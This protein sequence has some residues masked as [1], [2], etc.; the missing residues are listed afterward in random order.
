M[1]SHKRDPPRPSDTMSKSLHVGDLVYL[2]GDGNKNRGR[3]RYII[4]SIEGEWCNIRKLT[5]TLLKESSY[6]V[7][8]ND[9]YTVPSDLGSL[10]RPTASEADTHESEVSIV[11]EPDPVQGHVETVEAN[12]LAPTY[13]LPLSPGASP[14]VTQLPQVINV[15]P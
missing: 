1:L 13:D 7:K 10:S 9:C 14:I 3:D 6:R 15:P 11:V 2:Y 5:G 4:V 12:G 8:R